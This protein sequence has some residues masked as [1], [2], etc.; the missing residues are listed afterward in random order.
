MNEAREGLAE[1]VGFDGSSVQGFVR[2]FESDLVLRAKPKTTF[3]IPDLYKRDDGVGG[4]FCDVYTPEGE[5]YEGD[6]F[7]V[8]ERQVERAREKG[9]HSVNM[10]PE[11]EFFLL[12][13]DRQGDVREKLLD[14]GHYFGEGADEYGWVRREIVDCL[15]DLEIHVEADHHEVAPSQHEI[16][17]RYLPAS[18][19]A[20][21]A[22]L[23]RY[24]VKEVA[25]SH[26][27]YA[28]FMPKP[29][30]GQNGS[31]MHVHQSLFRS[32]G[33][34]QKNAFYDEEGAMHLSKTA[35]QYIA[36]ILKHAPEI[37]AVTN[38]WVNS[39]QRLVPGFEA[40]TWLAW[41]QKNRSALVRVPQYKPGKENST[42]IEVRFPDPACNIPL[43]FAM[44]I[45]AGLEGIERG[46]ELR[47][48]VE[49]DIFLLSG[50]EREEL[51]LQTLPGSLEEATA[52]MESSELARNVL[53][54]HIFGK[55]V[56]NQKMEWRE[57]WLEARG[58]DR[59]DHL[60]TRYELERLLPVL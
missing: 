44:M 13:D 55:L 30:Q 31:G 46:Y 36:G 59:E 29:L 41:G 15:E 52:R 38:Q 16:N 17:L 10:G 42:R 9:F 19:M 11:L 5:R 28:T 54:D 51:S 49:K 60:V 14:R 22:M 26:E 20:A 24:L 33:E 56:E 7:S 27:L 6:S 4:M 1:G 12:K 39:Y 32:E 3:I 47:D 37:A 18:E 34:S 57:Y 23:Y 48:P 40:P 53:G 25:K 50:F 45:G 43:A 35:Q 8:L 58:R 21:T 2:I